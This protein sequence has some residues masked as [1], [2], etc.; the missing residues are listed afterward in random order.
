MQ[1]LHTFCVKAFHNR[2]FCPRNFGM[3]KEM[4]TFAYP[5]IFSVMNPFN[6]PLKRYL[7][8]MVRSAETPRRFSFD[9]VGHLRVA[10]LFN[11]LKIKRN[12][13]SL[14]LR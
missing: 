14:Q 6:N 1:W 11:F 12:E 4:T 10:F 9:S 13:L 5:K 7:R 2:Y 8:P 3:S